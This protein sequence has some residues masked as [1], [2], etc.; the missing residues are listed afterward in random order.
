M[1][2]RGSV[3]KLKKVENIMDGDCMGKHKK[4]AHEVET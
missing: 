4:W 1:K 3:G 2:V